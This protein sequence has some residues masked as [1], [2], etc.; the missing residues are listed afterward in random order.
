VYVASVVA[1]IVADVAVDV[2]AAVVANETV[3][4]NR[5]A[6]AVRFSGESSGRL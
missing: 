3:G 1:V 2:A 6:V 4:F 5:A